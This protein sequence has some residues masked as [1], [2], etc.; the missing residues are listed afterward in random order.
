M[1]RLLRPAIKLTSWQKSLNISR[2]GGLTDIPYILSIF[3]LWFLPILL[4]DNF[5]E[6]KWVQLVLIIF[7]FS[8]LIAGINFKK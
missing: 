5:V 7:W 2:N 6:K 3:V 4:V 1:R 8:Y